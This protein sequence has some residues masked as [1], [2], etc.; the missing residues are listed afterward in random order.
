LRHNFSA[1]ITS[2]GET[3][4]LLMLI[5]LKY[6]KKTL[7]HRSVS[8]IL[9]CGTTIEQYVHILYSNKSSSALTMIFVIDSLTP[10]SDMMIHR[11]GDDQAIR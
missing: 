8:D 3:A 6:E 1:H 9:I 4:E 11:Y 2:I 5:S 10:A 7:L